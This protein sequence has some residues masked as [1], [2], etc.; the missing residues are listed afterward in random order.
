MNERSFGMLVAAVNARHREDEK[1]RAA[2]MGSS[3]QIQI[4]INDQDAKDRLREMVKGTS[5]ASRKLLD[6]AFGLTDGIVR[7]PAQ[8]AQEFKGTSSAPAIK[9]VEGQLRATIKGFCTRLEGK[10]LPGERKRKDERGQSRK[11]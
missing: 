3:V 4:L 7:S 9:E 6:L 5:G 11:N 1:R 10:T 2:K 8:V